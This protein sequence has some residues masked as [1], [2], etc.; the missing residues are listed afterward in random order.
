M[1]M[2]LDRSQ[3]KRK[4]IDNIPQ[5]F[6]I[7]LAVRIAR[8]LFPRLCGGQTES[9]PAA[10][11]IEQIIRWMESFCRDPSGTGRQVYLGL[12]RKVGDVDDLLRRI[13][14]E[15]AQET[16]SPATPDS[17]I[18]VVDSSG[19]E[20]LA[21]ALAA[22]LR[23]WSIEREYI[24]KRSKFSNADLRSSYMSKQAFTTLKGKHWQ[25]LTETVLYA[26]DASVAVDSRMEDLLWRDLEVAHEVLHTTGTWAVRDPVPEYLYLV[27]SDFDIGD[28]SSDTPVREIVRAVDAKLVAYFRKHPH[29]LKELSPRQFEEFICEMVTGFG[30]QAKLTAQTRD[31]GYD[32]FA[33]DDR[34]DTPVKQMYL[35]ECKRYTDRPVGVGAVRSLH[36]V[37]E[38]YKGSTGILVTTS[39]FSKPARDLLDR[40][41][42]LLQGVGL[43]ELLKWLDLYQRL[44]LSRDITD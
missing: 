16:A 38:T 25:L 7:A 44:R 14:R 39:Y 43:E 40:H 41:E 32:I 4:H 3:D 42:W 33:V 29:R 28:E 31:D 20:Q 11:S 8:R 27:P 18:L 10:E 5:S 24:L 6:K 36:S 37:T 13:V 17:P 26:W 22:A 23:P 35:L 19:Y 15:K 1:A 12:G 34:A 21:N 9:T 2:G 30:W